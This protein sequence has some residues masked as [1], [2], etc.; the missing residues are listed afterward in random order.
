MAFTYSH[1]HEKAGKACKD[2]PTNKQKADS[3]ASRS[4]GSAQNELSSNAADF[5]EEFCKNATH[6]S[7]I[8]DTFR[9]RNYTFT[10][11]F[12]FF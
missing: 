1:C 9:A 5:I 4:S 6:L 3:T 8:S 10:M 7:F 12:S 11:S 2:V